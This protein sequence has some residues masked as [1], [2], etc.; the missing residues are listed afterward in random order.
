MKSGNRA[1]LFKDGEPEPAKPRLNE[2]TEKMLL[3]RKPTLTNEEMLWRVYQ[4]YDNNRSEIE[5]R[6]DVSAHKQRAKMGIIRVLK[7]MS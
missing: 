6:R 3:Y 2:F 1:D 5:N 4:Y 7:W